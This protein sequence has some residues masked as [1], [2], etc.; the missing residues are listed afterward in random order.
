MPAVNTSLRPRT[1]RTPATPGGKTPLLETGAAVGGRRTHRRAAS[2]AV[3]LCIF[4]IV[5]LGWN[6]VS[7]WVAKQRAQ[8]TAWKGR[9]AVSSTSIAYGSALPNLGFSASLNSNAHKNIPYVAGPKGGLIARGGPVEVPE[10]DVDVSAFGKA[11]Q[12]ASRFARR[13]LESRRGAGKVRA[14]SKRSPADPSP[15]LAPRQSTNPT[16]TPNRLLTDFS[17]S[18]DESAFGLGWEWDQMVSFGVDNNRL[19]FVPQS[20]KSWMVMFMPCTAASTGA[21]TDDYYSSL[22]GYT[23]IEFTVTGPKLVLPFGV[24]VKICENS[25]VFPGQRF[26]TTVPKPTESY[27][28]FISWEQLFGGPLPGGI[29]P[30]IQHIGIETFP[31]AKYT[32][33]D[34]A[35]RGTCFEQPSTG[36]LLD[37]G[38]G[39]FIYGAA[40]DNV[41][42]SPQAYIDRLGGAVKPMI[43]NCYVVFSDHFPMEPVWEIAEPLLKLPYQ[44]ILAIFAMPQA[45]GGL[46]A[47]TDAGIKQLAQNCKK[48]N[49]L[50]LKVMVDFG[51]EGN[52]YWYKYGG[53]PAKYRE[54]WRRVSTAIREI[55][56]EGTSL[57][58]HMNSVVPNYWFNAMAYDPELDTNGNGVIDQEDDPWT[59]YWPGEEYVDWVGVSYYHYGGLRASAARAWWLRN[60]WLTFAR[61]VWLS[62]LAVHFVHSQLVTRFARCSLPGVE[63]PW[64]ENELP[65]SPTKFRDG[66]I[67]RIGTPHSF[68]RMFAE[69]YNIPMAIMET[70]SAYFLESPPGP[71]RMAMSQAWWRQVY[72][73]ETFKQLPLLR[74]IEWFEHE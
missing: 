45:D 22:Q 30:I 51:H 16:C 74:L 8:V 60:G 68:Y 39:K 48:L 37:P 1:P 3:A 36:R 18:L 33:D 34:I 29:V 62:F 44:S 66:L 31:K 40:I 10:W 55:A 21:A 23:G 38:L 63:Y 56:G 15:R 72:D 43:W 13:A 9:P 73:R 27:H 70:G 12:P 41:L 6:D 61:L 67:G 57:V 58:W 69:K 17:T 42:D 5:F 47:L 71:G 59:P 7:N 24:S 4:G 50:G 11:P 26:Y 14:E 54:A 32:I 53:Q 2:V 28:A 64:I 25:P 20:G 52:G 35:L 49:D 46:D 19:E 65:E